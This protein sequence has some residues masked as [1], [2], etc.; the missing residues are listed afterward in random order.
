MTRHKTLRG[1]CALTILLTALPTVTAS[2]FD[3]QPSWD[4]PGPSI[5]PPPPPTP[6]PGT[7]VPTLFS[8]DRTSGSLVSIDHQTGAVTTIGSIGMNVH[9]ADL[10]FHDDRLFGFVQTAPGSQAQFVEF[11]VHTGA[12][13][14]VT[15]ISLNGSP[16]I[17]AESLTHDG[18]GFVLGFSTGGDIYHSN[19]FARLS[20]DGTLSHVTDLSHHIGHFDIDGMGYDPVRERLVSVDTRPYP[21]DLLEFYAFGFD[22]SS[23]E[24]LGILPRTG[25]IAAINDIDFIDDR[26]YGIDQGAGMLHIFDPETAALLESIALNQTGLFGLAYGSV[27]PIPAP[28]AALLLFGL[29][30][31]RSRRRMPAA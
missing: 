14:S 27:T 29:Y 21:T 5:P 7:P 20:T 10:A 1:Y 2:A 12:A 11:D 19:A 8:V 15:N 18:N 4:P 25:S 30:G 23:I 24:T 26:M 28:G 13:L 16:V 17:F 6:T 31:C 9:I 3:D 22:Q